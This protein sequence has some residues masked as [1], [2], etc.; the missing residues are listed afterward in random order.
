MTNNTTSQ[1]PLMEEIASNGEFLYPLQKI[2]ILN[3][4]IIAKIF[5]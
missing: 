4:S 2:T 5:Y 1:S 3:D